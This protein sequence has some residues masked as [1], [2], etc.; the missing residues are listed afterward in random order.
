MRSEYP[1]DVFGYSHATPQ[2]EITWRRYSELKGDRAQHF[3]IR[4]RGTSKPE[5]VKIS[6]ACDLTLT[7]QIPRCSAAELPIKSRQVKVYPGLKKQSRPL[8]IITHA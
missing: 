1:K 2:N 6:A 3:S 8:L 7:L 5:V 4:Q